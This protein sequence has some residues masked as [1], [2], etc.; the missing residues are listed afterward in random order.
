M[1]L[2][3]GSVHNSLTFCFVS[4]KLSWMNHLWKCR[5]DLLPNLYFRWNGISMKAIWMSEV[6]PELTSRHERN[7]LKSHILP[8]NSVGHRKAKQRVR[9]SSARY[10]HLNCTQTHVLKLFITPSRWWYKG[11][12]KFFFI[13][14]WPVN[15]FISET[16]ILKLYE[17][18]AQESHQHAIKWNPWWKIF[19][20]VKVLYLQSTFVVIIDHTKHVY[21]TGFAFTHT[22][23]VVS[24]SQVPTAHQE[25]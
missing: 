11:L 7:A 15:D 5:A 25:H 3:L 10:L 19:C 6:M 21:T 9:G 17:N 13:I 23:V 4:A 1:V 16:C 12:L 20:M 24:T 14:W 18:P 8:L 2:H 22:L